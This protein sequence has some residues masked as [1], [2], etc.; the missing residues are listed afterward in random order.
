ML[1]IT[2]KSF[3]YTPS[4]NTDLRKKFKRLQAEQRA[5]EAAARAKARA[6]AEELEKH[7]LTFSSRRSSAAPKN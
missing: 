6:E 1:K 3:Q 7:V 2:D 4:Y 5:A